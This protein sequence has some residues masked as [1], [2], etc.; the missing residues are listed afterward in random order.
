VTDTLSAVLPIHLREHLDGRLPGWLTVHWYSS[1]EQAFELA[2]GADIGWFDM[3]NKADMA[4][5]IRSAT[6]LRWLNS[7]F[8]GV[9]AM[10]LPE[11]AERGVLLTNGAGINAITIAEYVVMGMLALAKGFPA[12]L[13]AQQEQ[14]W[15]KDAPGTRELFESRA[16]ILGSGGIGQLVRDRLLAFGVEVTMVRRRPDAATGEL[17]VQDWRSRLGQFDWII[18]A[19]PSTA[20]TRHMIAAAEF[21]AMKPDAVLVNVARGNVV[22]QDALVT[23]LRAGRL[24]GAFLDV[25][26]PEPLPAGHPLWTMDKVLITMHLSGRS[27]TRMFERAAA[28]FVDNL[29]RFRAGQPLANQVD[30]ALGY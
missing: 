25:T 14:V 15:L 9:D 18:L 23:A 26:D 24:G 19:V 20:E 5:A 8:A 6:R 1:K 28:R 27:Q 16:L 17:G 11:L 21:E 2:P 29:T 10:P 13:Q 30:L 22:D 4:A 7:I 12:V 3:Y